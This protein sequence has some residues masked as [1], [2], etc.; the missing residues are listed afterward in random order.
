MCICGLNVQLYR[1]RCL[2]EKNIGAGVEMGQDHT[3]LVVHTFSE[4]PHTGTK[5]SHH[6]T[7]AN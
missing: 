5:R 3:S 7:V 2:V 1:G 4:R 6:C